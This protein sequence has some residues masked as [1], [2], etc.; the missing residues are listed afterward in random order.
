M[1]ILALQRGED[2][3]FSLETTDRSI[4]ATSLAVAFPANDSERAGVSVDGD[5]AAASTD[6]LG[7]GDSVIVT[8]ADD[9]DEELEGDRVRLVWEGEDTSSILTTHTIQ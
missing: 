2:V 9:V 6:S 4:D 8:I 1:G 7:A 3:N 5:V